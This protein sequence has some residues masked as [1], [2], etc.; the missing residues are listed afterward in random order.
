[1]AI[2]DEE[3]LQAVLLADTPGVYFCPPDPEKPKALYPLCNKPMIEYA[4]EFLRRNEITE[5]I[6]FTFGWRA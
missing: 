4:I 2:K 6:I 5:I 3:S 1:M